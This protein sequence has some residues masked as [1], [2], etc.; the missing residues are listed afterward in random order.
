MESVTWSFHAATCVATVAAAVLLDRLLRRVSSET[1]AS[2]PTVEEEEA[3]FQRLLAAQDM[4]AFGGET[5]GY[6]WSQTDDEVA[7]TVPVGAE[8][9]SKD[10]HFQL[11]PSQISLS[12]SSQ[13]ILQAGPR[14]SCPQ[15]RRA[16]SAC[17]VSA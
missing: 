5:T 17:A 8:V 9:R 4:T 2:T 15:E 3:Y 7:V 1:P 12:V 10:I 16:T 13:L 6:S 14:L 11:T